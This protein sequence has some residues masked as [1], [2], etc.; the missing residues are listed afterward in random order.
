MK[1]RVRAELA[2]GSHQGVAVAYVAAQVGLKVRAKVHGAVMRRG[3][4]H[5]VGKAAHHSAHLAQPCR[6][7]GAFKARVPGYENPA[8][9]VCVGKHGLLLQKW[10]QRDRTEAGA[11]MLRSVPTRLT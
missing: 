11:M 10:L 8:S 4:G 3:G 9:L 1:D 7:P 2:H 6:Q 5:V